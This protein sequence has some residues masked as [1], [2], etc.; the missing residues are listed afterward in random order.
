MPVRFCSALPVLC[1]VCRS[2]LFSLGRSCQN[3]CEPYLGCHSLPPPVNLLS[4]GDPDA[5]PLYSDNQHHLNLVELKRSGAFYALALSTLFYWEL[6]EVAVDE[7]STRQLCW[8]SNNNSK[9][10][11]P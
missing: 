5:L 11:K 8:G 1:F 2:V 10:T 9:D 7:R 4:L 6:V 3:L